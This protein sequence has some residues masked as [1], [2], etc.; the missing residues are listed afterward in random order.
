MS[1]SSSP[2]DLERATPDL[3]DHPRINFMKWDV[4]ARDKA[5]SKFQEHE[6]LGLLGSFV[7]DTLWDSHPLNVVPGLVTTT[8]VTDVG[9][10]VRQRYKYDS[11]GTGGEARAL[12][13]EYEGSSVTD[14]S[15]DT[16]V[17]Y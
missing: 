13:A 10:G 9:A 5:A 17:S 6:P 15:R 16:F 4:N 12:Y 2:P 11:T 7:S 1:S 3:H 14:G 8:E